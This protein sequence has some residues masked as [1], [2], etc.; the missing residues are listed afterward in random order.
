M[1]T[2]VR[3]TSKALALRSLPRKLTQN[4]HKITRFLYKFVPNNPAKFDFFCCNL[5][6]A[7]INAIGLLEFRLN[8]FYLN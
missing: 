6:E 7:L 2:S 5:S 3:K 4:S 8:R 1:M